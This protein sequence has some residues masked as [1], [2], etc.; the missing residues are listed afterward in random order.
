MEMNNVEFMWGMPTQAPVEPM[1]KYS[2]ADAGRIIGFA[3]PICG[4]DIEERTV[5]CPQCNSV[6]NW[7]IFEE[8]VREATATQEGAKNE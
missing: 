6:F 8:E 7:L 3:C 2:T 4:R 5:G 1:A